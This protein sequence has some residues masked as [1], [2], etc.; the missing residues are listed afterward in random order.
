[1]S[2]VNDEFLDECI[3]DAFNKR[4]P[5]FC[6]VCERVMFRKDMYKGVEHPSGDHSWACAYM[7]EGC[8][9]E[10]WYAF[11]KGS[12]KWHWAVSNGDFVSWFDVLWMAGGHFPIVPEK[13]KRYNVLEKV[14]AGSKNTIPVA[15]YLVLNRIYCDC[16]SQNEG[17]SSHES[18]EVWNERNAAWK[19]LT[20]EER[21][22]IHAEERYEKRSG[23]KDD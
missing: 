17:F 2:K 16:L 14:T 15:R 11:H 22:S 12:S 7:D 9:G 23:D 6:M 19:K 18:D 4:W 1:M 8:K 21:R 20:D 5:I 13:G 3:E 10:E